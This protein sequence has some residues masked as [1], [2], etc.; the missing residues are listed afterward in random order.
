[1]KRFISKKQEELVVQFIDYFE[2]NN[3]KYQITGGLAGNLYGSK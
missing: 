1:M 2:S 3:I